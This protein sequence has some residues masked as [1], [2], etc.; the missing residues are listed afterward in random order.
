LKKFSF[1]TG[2]LFS[3]LAVCGLWIY[4]RAE[5]LL[6]A[7]AVF[8]SLTGKNL[9]GRNTVLQA[10]VLVIL[11]LL[12]V[13]L[14]IGLER[15]I[16]RKSRFTA[17]ANAII[18]L[19]L[20]I[21]AVQLAIICANQVLRRDDYWEIADARL[22]GFPGSMFYE[23]QRWNGRYTGW[24]LRSLHAVL[25][26]IPYI[27]IFLLLDLILLTIGTGMLAYRLLKDQK[28]AGREPADRRLL[29]VLIGFGLSLAFILISS[30]IWE[31]WFWGSGTMIYGFGISMC[32]LS[33]ALVLRAADEKTINLRK[34]IL[35][36]LCCFLTCGCSELCAVSLAAFLFIILIWKRIRE[37]TWNK[38]VLF[39]FGEICV[40]FICI[41]LMSG[42]LDYAGTWGTSE[43]TTE[44]G[45]LKK[46]IEWIPGM[47]GWAFSGL[48]GY[49]FIKSRELIIFLGIAFLIG[50]ALQFERRAYRKYLILAVLLAVLGHCVLLINT[51]VNYV[52]PRVITVGICWF[53]SA[54]ALVCLL[55]GSLLTRGKAK[56][57]CHIKLIF[58]ALLLCL[59]MNRFYT[60]NI[61]DARNIRQSW[62]IRDALLQQWKGN[63]K[64]AAA[65]SL[66]S[67]GSSRDD[68]SED[69]QD[70]FNRATARFYEVPAISAEGRCPPYGESF[71]TPDRYQTD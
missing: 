62:F 63:D 19:I 23:I 32:L 30:N 53:V 11:F 66:P 15:L 35:P 2:D 24:G 65:C 21:P 58:C 10:V 31:F 71:I 47:I 36:A 1:K 37:K 41:L 4:F 57:N 13:L 26:D 34:M 49:T 68:I 42:S 54:M 16:S 7:D 8:L 29:S 64:A 59:L 17:A 46:L 40:L 33:T 6:R 43:N 28:S 18:L 70:E 5:I 44:P 61:D 55:A 67:P 3:F 48:Y 50:T 12:C 39:F 56:W 9:S 45:G 51:M 27:D 14:P 25:P 38:Q 69:P 52:P 20:A 60:E 22:Y